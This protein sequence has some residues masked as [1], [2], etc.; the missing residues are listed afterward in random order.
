MS[1]PRIKPIGVIH[2][3]YKTA[4]E[5]PRQGTE[6]ISEIEIFDEYADGLKDIGT[7]PYV[8]VFYWLHRSTHY[9]LSVRPP[10]DVRER[11]LFATRSPHRPNPLGYALA[12]L[13]ER[14]GNILRVKRLDAI[15]GTPVVDIK[16][17]IAEIDTP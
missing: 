15:E 12:R 14:E 5:A 10:S 16:P 2:S 3:P 11:G 8:H 1:S 13:I 17:Y 4:A 9:S 7:F 6:E